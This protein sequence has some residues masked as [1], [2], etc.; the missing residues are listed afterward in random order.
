MID[1]CTLDGENSSDEGAEKIE[2][3][4][5]ESGKVNQESSSAQN[6]P[7]ANFKATHSITDNKISDYYENCEAQDSESRLIVAEDCDDI[8]TTS[9]SDTKSGKVSESS[10]F[11]DATVDTEKAGQIDDEK[12]EP[13][14]Y[15]NSHFQN[16]RFESKYL[17]EK[18]RKEFQDSQL[19]NTNSK[20]KQSKHFSFDLNLQF[21]EN[22]HNIA[23]LLIKTQPL[24]IFATIYQSEYFSWCSSN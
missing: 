1:N 9:S 7:E 15:E 18:Y 23:L 17:D 11:C 14:N 5:S 12:E 22:F 20:R 6:I 8:V 4:N 24:I 10:K 21:C 16:Y 19:C 3:A 13:K 2:K